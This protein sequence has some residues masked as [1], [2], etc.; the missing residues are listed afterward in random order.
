MTDLRAVILV[1]T[2][3]LRR[4]LPSVRTILM[5][6]LALVPAL[7]VFLAPRL[8]SRA[9]P[10][11]LLVHGTWFVS[12]QVVAPLAALLAGSAVIA[13]EIEAGTV[14][15][16]F[17]RP[18]RRSALLVGR[19]LAALVAVE[20]ILLGGHLVMLAALPAG[21]PEDSGTLTAA[22]MASLQGVAL[23]GAAYLSVFTLL[24]AR[25]K[26][27]MVAGLGYAFAVEGLVGNTPGSLANLS[28]LHHLRSRVAAVD[29][30][31]AFDSWAARHEQVALESGAE[32]LRALLFVVAGCLVLACW[33]LARRQVTTGSGPR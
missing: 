32:A 23:A 16:L 6:L 22:A 5:L 4:S 13:E 17:T 12:L 26:R 7:L 14:T 10:D 25:L 33:L 1:F 2:L 19:W 24:G 21:R 3:A 15:Y 11:T 28:L 27:P 31:G 20:V 29:S 18:V 9:G 30:G 8:G